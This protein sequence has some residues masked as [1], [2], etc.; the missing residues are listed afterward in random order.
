MLIAVLSPICQVGFILALFW[1]SDAVVA[2][3]SPGYRFWLELNFAAWNLF[4]LPVIAAMAAEL[5]WEQDRDAY[6]WR[7][8]LHQPIPKI[9][10]YFAKLVNNL[11]LFIGTQLLLFVLL[12]LGGLILSLNKFLPMGSLGGHIQLFFSYFFFSFL[13]SIPVVVF[14]TWFSFRF[15]GPAIALGAALVGTW[16]GIKLTD[17]TFLLQFLPWGLSSQSA[18][19]FN[20]SNVL[21]WGYCFGAMVLAAL[22]IFV[23]SIDFIKH[24]FA[25][26]LERN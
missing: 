25:K 14:Q 4:V 13:A 2:R 3:N 23:G 7:H 6:A 22:L 20:R 1:F 12:L 19:V 5:S 16:G 9:N 10:Q 21:P 11:L 24:A 26:S 8:L 17:S 15:P 18:T